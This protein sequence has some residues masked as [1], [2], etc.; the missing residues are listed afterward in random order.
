MQEHEGD[1]IGAFVEFQ[2]GL[3]RRQARTALDRADGWCSRI[4]SRFTPAGLTAEEAQERLN[5]D[6]RLEALTFHVMYLPVE[7]EL[8]PFGYDLFTMVPTTFAPRVRYP[9]AVELR[10][11]SGRHD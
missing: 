9:G 8:K 6:P 4:S 10:D 5:A 7:P 1:R 11:R 3:P 2:R